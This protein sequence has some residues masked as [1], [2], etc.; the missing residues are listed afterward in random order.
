MRFFIAWMILSFGL[1]HDSIM[2]VGWALF[3]MLWKIGDLIE[4]SR[5]K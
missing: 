5:R 4:E 3:F 1:C 2:A